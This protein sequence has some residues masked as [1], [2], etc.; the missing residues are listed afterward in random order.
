MRIR[1]NKLEKGNA[2]LEFGLSM[3]ILIPL[4]FGTVSFGINLGNML[5]CTQITRDVAHMYAQGVDFSLAGNQNIAVNLVQGL[6]GMTANSGNGVLILSQILEV[7]QADCTAAGISAAQCTNAGKRVFTNRIVIGAS[8][9]RASN[10]GVPSATYVSANGNIG[11]TDYYKQSSVQASNFDDTILPQ[12]D[13]QTA[14]VVEAYFAT[15]NLA[16][17][18]GW[19]SNNTSGVYMRAIF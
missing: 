18:G 17:L 11:S 16:F 4:L 10:F 14:F 19:S 5:Q 2:A 13:G 8:A 15:P 9:L 6:G 1:P 7:Y 12:A 3:T